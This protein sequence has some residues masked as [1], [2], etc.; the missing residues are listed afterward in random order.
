MNIDGGVLASTFEQGASSVVR[1]EWQGVL[2]DST[3]VLVLKVYRSVLQL[4]SGPK[5]PLML[6]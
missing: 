5:Q 3:L 2:T 4:L 6:R 1:Q